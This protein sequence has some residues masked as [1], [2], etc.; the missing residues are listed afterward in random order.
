[1]YNIGIDLG[2]THIAVGITDENGTLIIKDSIPTALPRVAD[3]IINDI[4]E[5]AKLLLSQAEISMDN[6]NWVGIGCPGT[7][8]IE[9]GILEYANNL[10]FKNV[11]IKAM[12]EQHLSK[13]CYIEN[14]ANAAAYG[15]FIAGAAIGSSS[16]VVIT[17]GTGVGGGIIID[18]KIFRGSNFAG[19]ELGHMVIELDGIECNCGRKGCFETY[20]SATGLIYMTKQVMVE[21]NESTMWS[22]CE[23][24]I[25]KVSGKT[26][27]LAARAGDIAGKLVV[28][29][30]IRYLGIGLVNII[31][32]FQPDVLCV[33]GGVS[34]EG[35]YLIK[36]LEAIIEKERYSKYS[37]KQTKL[38]TAELGNDA[39]IIG[40]AMLGLL[41]N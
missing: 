4:A 22:L 24:D 13:I 7:A 33:G 41:Y 15:E 18:K 12:I 29:K 19:A 25:A 37:V 21:N 8:N 16:A 32:I 34:K 3:E 28:D 27:F 2:G 20:S 39:G 17:L 23:E 36:P 38:C 6:V 5:L 9:T 35:D 11:P 26:A 30:Y 10:F 31:N 40:A 14:D 1:V